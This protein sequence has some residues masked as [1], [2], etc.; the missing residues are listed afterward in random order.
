MFPA[1]PLER[2]SVTGLKHVNGALSM[3]RSGP[4]S[5]TS[6]FSIMIGDQPE[7]DF[8][9][10]RNADGQ[11]FAVFGK[12]VG[13]MDVVKKIQ[14][15][16]TG[17]DAAPTGTETLEPPIKILR[18]YRKSAGAQRPPLP[19]ALATTLDPVI[20][21]LWADYDMTAAMGHV[22]FMSRYW[23]LPGNEGFDASI[24]RVRDRLR[25]AGFVD[26]GTPGATMTMAVEA[27]AASRGWDYSVGTLAIARNGR[28]DEVVLSREKDRL[29]LCINSFSTAPGGVV[30][31]L[32]DVG[33]G[34]RDQDYTGKDLK[35]AV[36]LGDADVGNL[37]RRAVTTGGA[38]GVI[39]TTLPAY[40]NANPPGAPA[41]PRDEWDILQWGSVTYDEARKGFGFKASPRAAA[42]LRKALAS[43]PASVHV[44]VASTFSNEPT[45]LLAGEIR[46]RVAPDE[47]VVLAAHVQE[48]GA[49]DN[50]SGVATLTELARALAIGIKQGRI[51]APAR[52]ITFLWLTEIS[53]SRQ[54]MQSHPDDAKRVRYMQSMD[55]TGEDVAKT[56][57]AFLIE[58]WPDPGAVWDRPWDPHSEWGRG[59]VRADSL[60]GDL[61]NDLHLAICDRVARKSGWV[62]RTN[63]YEGGSDHSEF[64]RAGVPSLLNWHFTDRYYHTN[65]DTPDKTSAAEMRNVGVAVAASAWL[66]ASANE[67]TSLAVAD[68]VAAAGRARLD[69][70]TREGAKIAAADANAAVAQA[71]EA[72]I[73]AAWRK[74]SAEAIASVSRLVTGPVTPAFAARLDA[75]AAPFQGGK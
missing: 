3:A 43:G 31:P 22:E 1:I 13:G 33:R 41:T 2:T 47:R 42:T 20:D 27:S 45:R 52:T 69:V 14:A 17:A 30:A 62:V 38:L 25:A 34:D 74:W 64:G 35:G 16:K 32:V 60:K 7:L 68:L 44:T 58:R 56:G 5:A 72:T 75:L 59:N 39:S 40:L 65:F 50:A 9:G 23:R 18:A 21:A 54:W 49:N 11:G 36:V 6:S 70:E 28:P 37:W 15:S 51:P 26:A 46:G 61:L 66:L 4:D 53:G 71:R 73:L 48:P 12:V 19:A 8:G 55:M 63:P 24:D 10:K 67:A 29:A 57:G